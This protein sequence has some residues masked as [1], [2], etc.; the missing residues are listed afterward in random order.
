MTGLGQGAG[1][2]KEAQT[3]TQ[4]PWNEIRALG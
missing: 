1:T 4:A 3:K 2:G